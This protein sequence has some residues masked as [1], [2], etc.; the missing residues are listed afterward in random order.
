MRAQSIIVGYQI[1]LV[2][3]VA[4]AGYIL[5]SDQHASKAILYGGFVSVMASIVMACR[6]NQAVN[7]VQKGSQRGGIYVYLGV[8]ERLLVAIALFGLGLVWLKLSPT[9]TVVGLIAGQ[10]GFIL[11]GFRVK[12]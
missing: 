11:G 10:V 3:I 8:V 4:A 7:K 12:E 6:L 5:Y 1:A 2:L 9:Y